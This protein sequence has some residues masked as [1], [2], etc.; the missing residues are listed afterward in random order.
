MFCNDCLI[1]IIF[2]GQNKISSSVCINHWIPFKESEIDTRDVIESHFMS[3]Y[4]KNIK[5]SKTA[6][7]VLDSARNL[8]SYYHSKSDS[9]PNASYYDIREY[10]QGRN[11]KGNLN[12]SS[13]DETYN[14]LISDLKEKHKL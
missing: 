8:Y 3:D 6:Q 5:F 7:D 9:N 14:Q 11:D 2:H 13:E 1:Y 4:I 10:F 12:V